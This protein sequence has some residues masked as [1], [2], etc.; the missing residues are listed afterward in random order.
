MLLKAKELRLEAKRV[1]C[2]RYWW[3]VLATFVSVSFALILAYVI[4]KTTLCFL[5]PFWSCSIVLAMVI[6]FSFVMIVLNACT[7]LGYT[8]FSLCL[9]ADERK[10]SLDVLFDYFEQYKWKAL[11][12]DI[13]IDLKITAWSLLFVVPGIIAAIRYSQA[14]FIFAENPEMSVTKAIEE[15]KTMMK[16]QKW[17]YFC[18]VLSYTGWFLLSC[19]IPCVGP[20]LLMPYFENGCAAFYLNR[21]AGENA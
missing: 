16:N 15:S 11:W 9:Y 12:L 10:P 21:K 18:F 6:V 4:K 2:K 13:L 8:K 1:L 17:N 19:I 7:E 20:I 5:W 14:K 3:T